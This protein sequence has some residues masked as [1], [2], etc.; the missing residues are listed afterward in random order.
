MAWVH[1]FRDLSRKITWAYTITLVLK[2]RRSAALTESSF[3]LQ[4]YDPRLIPDGQSVAVYSITKHRVWS[5]SGDGLRVILASLDAKGMFLISRS[6]NGPVTDGYVKLVLADVQEFRSLSKRFPKPGPP[7]GRVDPLIKVVNRCQSNEM[8]LSLT[9][10]HSR[11]R[12]TACCFCCFSCLI[13]G[14]ARKAR[15]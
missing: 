8:W 12:K 13:G 10:A 2:S 6:G 7:N 11:I 5:C 14:K 1:L 3:F 4:G 9:L 15:R